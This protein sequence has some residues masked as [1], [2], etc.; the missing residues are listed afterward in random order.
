MWWQNLADKIEYTDDDLI[1]IVF[2]PPKESVVDYSKFSDVQARDYHG[3]WTTGGALAGWEKAEAT[4]EGRQKA[5]DA[6]YASVLAETSNPETAALM[7]NLATGK[8]DKH[9]EN[10]DKYR[11]GNLEIE[12]DKRLPDSAQ[13]AKEYAAHL[14]ALQTAHPLDS[15]MHVVITSEDLMSSSGGVNAYTAGAGFMAINPVNIAANFGSVEGWHMPA[16]TATNAREYTL[17]HEWGHALDY[18][19]NFQPS[20]RTHSA[21]MASNM[22]DQLSGYGQT[23]APEMYAEMFAQKYMESKYP[24]V[25]TSPLTPLVVTGENL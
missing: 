21:L 24:D 16:E 1:G 8:Y 17:A 25:K 6:K 9:Y 19:Y 14:D 12:V 4:P 5:Y 22:V 10:Y 23:K 18:N 3:R 2:M 20:Q 11:K 7:A 15:T 13:V